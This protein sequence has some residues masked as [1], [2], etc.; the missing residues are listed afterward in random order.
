VDYSEVINS[1]GNTQLLSADP[2]HVALAGS[3]DRMDFEFVAPG[4]GPDGMG[5]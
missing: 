2:E 1:G 3:L 4:S 5:V